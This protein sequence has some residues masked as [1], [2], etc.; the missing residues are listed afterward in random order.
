MTTQP[1]YLQCK[2]FSNAV[3]QILQLQMSG[4]FMNIGLPQC[5]FSFRD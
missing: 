3:Q 4:A 5:L 2:K 1:K